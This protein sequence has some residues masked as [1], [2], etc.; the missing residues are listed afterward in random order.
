MPFLLYE[1]I[2]QK[3]AFSKALIIRNPSM[4][5]IGGISTFSKISN[6]LKVYVLKVLMYSVSLLTFGV[7]ST[8]WVPLRHKH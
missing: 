8:P 7:R 6:P 2:T 4:Q 3:L 1:Y 5:V